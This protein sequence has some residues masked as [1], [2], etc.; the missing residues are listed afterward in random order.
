MYYT[1]DAFAVLAVMDGVSSPA[2]LREGMP[3]FSDDEARVTRVPAS[4]S[5]A[6]LVVASRRAGKTP[7][8][9]APRFIVTEAGEVAVLVRKA[10]APYFWQRGFRDDLEEKAVEDFYTGQSEPLGLFHRCFGVGEELCFERFALIF[11]SPRRAAVDIALL[12]SRVYTYPRD[13]DYIETAVLEG[14]TGAHYGYTA[15]TRRLAMV[16]CVAAVH[17]DRYPASGR[18]EGVRLWV[19][20]LTGGVTEDACNCVVLCTGEDSAEGGGQQPFTDARVVIDPDGAGPVRLIEPLLWLDPRGVLWCFYT[21]MYKADQSD[22][23]RGGWG[24]DDRRMGVWAIRTQEPWKQDPVWSRPIR[25]CDGVGATPPIVTSDGRWLFSAYTS[26]GKY[27]QL[28]RLGP[29]LYRYVSDEDIWLHETNLPDAIRDGLPE[30]STVELPDGSFRV[31]YRR[32]GGISS[33]RG[34]YRD[35]SWEWSEEGFACDRASGEVLSHTSSRQY[36]CTLH[37]ETARA[38]ETQLFVFHDNRGAEKPSARANLT[39]ALSLDGGESFPHRL[40][41]HAGGA[42]YPLATQDQAGNIY[43]AYDDGRNSN[44]RILLSRLTTNDI[45]AGRLVS[46]GSYLNRVVADNLSSFYGF[47]EARMLNGRGMPHPA[48]CLPTGAVLRPLEPEAPLYSDGGEGER[49]AA[50]PL[51]LRGMRYVYGES[52]NGAELVVQESGGMYAVIRRPVCPNGYPSESHFCEQSV[53]ED[54]GFSEITLYGEG[55]CHMIDVPG[56]STVPRY[57]VLVRSVVAGEHLTLPP[58]ALYI[59]R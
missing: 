24:S 26:W 49:L 12:P 31:F 18:S 38:R 28:D 43:V 30:Q 8:Q 21:Q 51:C 27:C 56:M 9:P 40:L 39:A 13:A 41:L 10:D 34:V 11:C 50:L 53:L 17:Y 15:G 23:P 6:A 33:E 42:S 14:R 57:S 35:G 16:P 32:H 46:P 19:G 55:L 58:R 54:L 29:N 36:L 4:L 37:D 47:Y 45:R 59:V 48:V 20:Y 25:I 7:T 5:G 52:D 2:V 44:C 1:N 22:L 3:V